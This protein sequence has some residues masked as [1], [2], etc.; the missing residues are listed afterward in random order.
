MIVDEINET[1]F[2]EKL[3]QGYKELQVKFDSWNRLGKLKNSMNLDEF[4][5]KAGYL[6]RDPTIWAY[7]TLKDKQG[8]KL[9]VHPFQDKLMNDKNRFVHV[10]AANQI[11]K[12]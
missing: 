4:T 5:K 2:E 7:A 11:G 8:N 9:E 12:T 3:E 6:L 10:H 1:N